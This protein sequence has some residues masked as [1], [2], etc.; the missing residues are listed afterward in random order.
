MTEQQTPDRSN[1]TRLYLVV[2]DDIGHGRAGLARLAA[3][4]TWSGMAMARMVAP[5]R[6]AAYDQSVQPKIAV[7]VKSEDQLLRVMDECQQAGL[8]VT[9]VGAGNGMPGGLCIGPVTRAELPPFLAKQRLLADDERPDLEASSPVPAPGEDDLALI[10]LAR[11]D[12]GIPWGKLAAQA[13]HAA[14][15]S[16]TRSS[17]FSDRPRPDGWEQS[18]MPVIYAEVPDLAAFDAA[19]RSC[20][21]VPCA[22]IVDA[23]RTVFGGAPTPT[24]VGIGPALVRELPPEV[25]QWLPDAVPAPTPGPGPR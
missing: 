13:G 14:L 12:A 4:A 9:S 15:S 16:V 25:R 7:R 21:R 17:I 2:R 20:R 24:V 6:H 5:E 22:R 11:A 19:Y 3:Q 18:G 10:L 23:G 8:P 1:E